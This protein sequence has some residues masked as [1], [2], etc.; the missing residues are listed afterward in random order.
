MP[1][2]APEFRMA[3]LELVRQYQGDRA[4]EVSREGVRLLAEALMQLELSEQVGSGRFGQE[5]CRY[6]GSQGGCRA[7]G[8]DRLSGQLTRP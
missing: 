1:P 8:G 3:L 5:V 2:A 7:G 4:L 6:D